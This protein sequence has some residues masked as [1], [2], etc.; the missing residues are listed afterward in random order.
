MIRVR[1]NAFT[2][3]HSVFWEDHRAFLKGKFVCF[4]HSLRHF[5]FSW[6]TLFSTRTNFSCLFVW[7]MW[8]FKCMFFFLLLFMYYFFS[9]WV[10]F[11]NHLRITGLQGKGEGISLNACFFVFFTIIIIF[12][13]FPI[14]VFFHNHL[15]ITGLQGKEEGIPLIPHYHFHPFHRHLDISW[16]IT[17]ESS[18]LLIGSSWTRTGFPS[19]SR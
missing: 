3:P 17:T 1:V 4:A 16:A 13:F 9:I 6:F 18:P 14:W 15:R 5:Y 19:A 10:F 2:S 7:L 11:H 12:F 8:M